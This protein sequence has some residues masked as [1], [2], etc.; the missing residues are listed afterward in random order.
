MSRWLGSTLAALLLGG[1]VSERAIE[2][3]IEPP[4]GPLGEPAIPADAVSWEVRLL[5]VD[6]DDACPGVEASAEARPFGELAEAQAFFV[7][8]A[9]VAVGEVPSGRWAFAALARDAGCRPLLYGCA[10]VELDGDFGEAVV[11]PVAPVDVEVTCGCRT[12]EAGTCREI[13]RVCR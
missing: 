4:R 12:C 1:C 13:A 6:D 11:V 2:L 9:G 8:G 3:V 5:R 10:R 7:G